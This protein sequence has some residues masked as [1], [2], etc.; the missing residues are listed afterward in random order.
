MVPGNEYNL[1]EK[2]ALKVLNK[3]GYE[4]IDKEED[5]FTGLRDDLREV[6]LETRLKKFI[7]SNNPWINGNNLQ[8]A[9]NKLKKIRATDTMQINKI[10]HKRLVQHISVLQ[11]RGRGNR[12]QTVKYIDYANPEN[13]DFLAISQFKV[14][15]SGENIIP[16]IVI[17]LN[18]IP[19][20]RD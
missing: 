18:G 16:D 11:D 10:V 20:G 6:L 4:I 17:F 2:P 14:A 7:K 3:L 5:E 1:V 9:V 12:N 15:S 13:N 8:R 19:L